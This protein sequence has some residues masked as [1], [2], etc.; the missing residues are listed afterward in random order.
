[1]ESVFYQLFAQT[2][3]INKKYENIVQ[4]TGEGFNIFRILKLHA[5]E[6]RTHSAFLA[7]LLNPKGSHGQRDVFLNLF[8]S[9]FLEVDQ[10][11]HTMSATVIVE[12]H[13]GFMNDGKTE[14]GRIDIA[15]K[16][17][18]GNEIFI[19]NKIY[20][21]DQENQLVR[22][23]NYNKNA[24]LFYLCLQGETVSELSCGD[25]K[26][27]EHF[28]VITYKKEIIEW[29][30]DCRKEAVSHPILRESITQYINL[31]K[32]LTGQTINETMNAE[33]IGLLT[34]DKDSLSASFT[35]ANTVDAACDKLLEKLKIIVEEE[36][37]KELSVIGEFHIN[38]KDKYS[39]FCFYKEDWQLSS[40]CF[41][42]Q[43]TS[44]GLT[45]GIARDKECMDL[46]DPYGIEIYK[47]L[48]VLGGELNTWW[49]FHKRVEEPYD[50]WDNVEPWL[51]IVDGSIKPWIKN[52]VEEILMLLDRNKL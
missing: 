33:L 22:Y 48:S 5:A 2:N 37:A 19:E 15:I 9:R 50:D 1:M 23:Y 36:I 51:A 40:I 43:Y 49:P 12:K 18:S 11:F 6:N 25:L 39:Q 13:I 35:I 44:S 45:Y 28:H 8:I 16:D 30:N 20:A 26:K 24:K 14:G 31:I 27:T 38:W 4:A 41:Q 52:K 21:I 32:Y 3:A 34:K 7:E 47:K 17:H 10:V 29:L 46:S 42:F